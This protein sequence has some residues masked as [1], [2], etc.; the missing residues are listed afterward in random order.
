MTATEIKL[1]S[2]GSNEFNVRTTRVEEIT[3]KKLIPIVIPTSTKN[4]GVGP[5][6]TLIVD[7]L[8]VETRFN[9]DGIVEAD[10]RTKFRGMVRA[11]GTNVM[12]YNGNDYE[13]NFEKYILSEV[14]EDKSTLEPK[15]YTVEF[16]VLV[17][18][19]YG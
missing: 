8:T 18:V 10:D 16:T 14:P 7:L 3:S 5:K 12:V 13:I 17:G 1:D 19:D 9:I 6:D 4:W 11:G 15:H 2:G